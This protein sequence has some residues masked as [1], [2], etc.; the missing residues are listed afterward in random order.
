MSHYV[1]LLRYYVSNLFFFFQAEDG[2]RDTS[3]TGV[4][5]CALPISPRRETASWARRSVSSTSF[6]ARLW[7]WPGSENT[8]SI[9][10]KSAWMAFWKAMTSTFV[11]STSPYTWD[12]SAPESVMTAPGKPRNWWMPSRTIASRPGD[13]PRMY[14]FVIRICAPNRVARSLGGMIGRFGLTTG[15]RVGVATRP[16]AVSSTPIRASPS[17]SRTSNMRGH[18]SAANKAF[19]R[20]HAP[21]R[22]GYASRAGS[23]TE[24]AP[25]DVRSHPGSG[26]PDR[27]A[28]LAEGNPH[29]GRFL[30]GI[31]A[32][33][34]A[35]ARPASDRGRDRPVR[36]GVA[37]RA[38]SLLR[39]ESPAPGS[40]ARLARVR[41]P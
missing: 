21:P 23:A 6:A 7:S 8:S 4:Q 16:C 33:P 35:R 22:K 34:R 1:R 18:R 32:A 30:R 40:L 9:V 37:P 39:A 2:I 19:P 14:A 27:G 29:V 12:W 17:R 25:R 28:A 11:T 20:L 3:V 15:A 26:L 10:P 5:T 31:E 36:R 13:F 41:T 38:A 24:H